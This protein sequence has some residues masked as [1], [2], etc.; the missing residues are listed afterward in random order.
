MKK[1]AKKTAASAAKKPAKKAAK[2]AKT[3]PAR[4]PKRQAPGRRKTLHPALLKIRDQLIHKR[5][6]IF[7]IL[8][9]SR[10]V[11]LNPSELNFSNEIDLA[12]SL[13]SREMAFTL[14]S[15]DRNELKLIE[16]AL[17]KIAR[18]TYGVCES[19]SKTISMK[20]L[21]IMPLAPFCIECQAT[22]ERP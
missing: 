12:A 8:Q 1:P 20:R 15:R 18:G 6:E 9:T 13:E 2:K 17:F 4:K 19:C 10:E 5:Q 16:A 7:K 3:A 22:M 11:E 14:S 21:G